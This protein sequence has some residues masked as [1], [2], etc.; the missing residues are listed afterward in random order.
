[1]TIENMIRNEKLRY[2]FNREATKILALSSSKIY[3]YEYLTGEEIVT[4]DP[5]KI[6][7]QSKCIYSLLQKALEKQVQSIKILI[8]VD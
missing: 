6:I 2:N 8:L 4:F 3:K 5:S 7:Q 1:M